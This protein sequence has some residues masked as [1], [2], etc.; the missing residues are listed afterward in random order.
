MGRLIAACSLFCFIT[1]QS[2]VKVNLNVMSRFI[3]LEHHAGRHRCL[4][5]MMN[6][7]S[8]VPEEPC[9]SDVK[10]CSWQPLGA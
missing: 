9:L 5:M 1:G 2:N 8:P 3:P 10:I 7:G 6:I 4:L